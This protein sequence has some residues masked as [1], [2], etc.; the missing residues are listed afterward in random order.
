MPNHRL[1]GAA[2]WSTEVLGNSR[3]CPTP[4]GPLLAITGAVP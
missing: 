1:S 3:P 2:Y 4:S